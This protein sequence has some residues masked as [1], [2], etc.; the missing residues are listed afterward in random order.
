MT[1]AQQKRTARGRF[2]DKKDIVAKLRAQRKAAHDPAARKQL[3]ARLKQALADLETAKKAWHEAVQREKASRRKKKKTKHEKRLGEK[4]LNYPKPDG[5]VFVLRHKQWWRE[6]VDP[7]WKPPRNQC[8]MIG[9]YIFGTLGDKA[10]TTKAVMLLKAT[11]GHSGA[12]VKARVLDYFEQPECKI[13]F[14]NVKVLEFGRRNLPRRRNEFY[15]QIA[16]D[17]NR[18]KGMIR[19]EG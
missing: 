17:H 12:E 16:T 13:Y 1:L 15:L 11:N 5:F 10:V 19:E 6:V 2:K 9:R 3:T 14:G 18:I 7:S 4:D 8:R